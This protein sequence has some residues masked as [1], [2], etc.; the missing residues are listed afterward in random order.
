MKKVIGILGASGAAGE[1]AAKTLLKH[2]DEINLILGGRNSE[3]LKTIYGSREGVIFAKVDVFQDELLNDFVK[4]CD[5]VINCT[6]PAAKVQDRV[7]KACIDED[8]LY[9][10][11]SGDK[12]M[13]KK[14]KEYADVKRNG[15]CVISAGTYPG[16]TELYADYIAK[17]YYDNVTELKEYFNGNIALSFTGAYD[18][19]ASLEKS[20]GEGMVFCSNGSLA[21]INGKMEYQKK[22]PNPA[23]NVNT[24]PLISDE[25]LETANKNKIENAY[26]Y[27]TFLNTKKLMDFISIKASKKFVTEEDKKESAEKVMDIFFDKTRKEYFLLLVESEG[28]KE[29]Q[30]HK[31]KDLLL[32][33]GN[34]NVI[35]GNVAAIGALQLIKNTEIE[36]G[37]I[38]YAAGVLDSDEVIKYLIQEGKIK[39]SF[40]EEV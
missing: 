33:E 4:K 8:V 22:L 25:F 6:G 16:L 37:R 20:E 27:N 9:M 28:V 30:E 14:L 32:C 35:T 5:L 24:I 31:R 12:G 19:I 34:W 3:K 23:G 38:Y 17:N 36:K 21:K 2:D 18:I 1:G 29:G 40:S 7:G 13:Y 11:V 10:D 26:F 15:I 39:T